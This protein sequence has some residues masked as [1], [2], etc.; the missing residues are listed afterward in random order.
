M[1]FFR[2]FSDLIIHRCAREDEVLEIL[3][4]Y[5]D[6]PCG[7]LFFDKCTTYKVLHSGYYWPSIFKDVSKYVRS[8]DSFQR[9]GRP[10]SS[11]EIP[12]QAQVMIEPFEKWA[13][14]FVGTFTHVP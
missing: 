13:L 2:T 3:R 11:I 9:I 1:I 7:G 14:E 12:L 10:M 5:H 8:C 4:S 6:G